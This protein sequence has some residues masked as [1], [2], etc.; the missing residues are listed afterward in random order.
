MFGAS[1]LVPY[2]ASETTNRALYE[3]IWSQVSRLVS[4]E[5]RAEVANSGQYPFEL[6]LV[7]HAGT[8]CGRCSWNRF[9]LGCPVPC[10]EA[11]SQFDF[12]QV[13]A[14]DWSSAAYYL[15][16]SLVEERKYIE[17]KKKK[18]KKENNNAN[19]W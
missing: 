10:D 11:L 1:M 2:R 8:A 6:K 13:V 5:L 7:N 4:A 14:I 17:V 3:R 16:F 12:S 9:C 18:K 15:H 19:I